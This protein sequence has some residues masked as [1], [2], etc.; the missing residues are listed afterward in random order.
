LVDL[1]ATLNW[2]QFL[3]SIGTDMVLSHWDSYGYNLN[4][5]HIYHDPD[6]DQ[7]HFSPWSTDLAFGWYP[8]SSSN[9]CGYLGKDPADYRQG[10][11]VRRCQDNSACRAA[12]DAR[13][14]SLAD[15][16]ENLDLV[17]RVDAFAELVYEPVTQ[18]NKSWYSLQDWEEQVSCIQGWLERRPD[19]VRYLVGGG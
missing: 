19:Q 1:Q 18:D 8:W 10:Y 5:T 13:V 14:M 9:G 2:E 7:W 16:L 11:L 15:E 12:L 6:T 17:A 4:N 3:S